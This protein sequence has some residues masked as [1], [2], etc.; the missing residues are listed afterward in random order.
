MKKLRDPS[1]RLLK[2]AQNKI[3]IFS[4]DSLANRKR[5]ANANADEWL[6]EYLRQAY[7]PT[8]HDFRKLRKRVNS[9]R[10]IYNANYR[11]IRSKFYAHKEITESTD[12]ENMF[13]KTN[14]RELQKVFVFVNA[15]YEAL[16][17]M[18]NN[19]RKPA[20]RPM[21][22]SIKNMRK[23]RNISSQK[24]TVQ[25]RIVEELQ[26]FFELFLPKT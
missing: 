11:D 26:K 17:E 21:R 9:Y 1:D 2:I 4:K 24:R 23:N 25:E 18:L 3:D 10:K 8:K 12:I 20:L 13:A 16:W 7:E 19:G 22:Y 15:L 14:I 5:R 6:D